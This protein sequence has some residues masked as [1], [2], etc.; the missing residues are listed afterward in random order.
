MSA[1]MLVAALIVVLAAAAWIALDVVDRRRHHRLE[2]QIQQAIDL[3]G[4]VGPE[5][6]ADWGQHG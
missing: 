2:Q 6:R 3:L 4:P 5:D 1:V